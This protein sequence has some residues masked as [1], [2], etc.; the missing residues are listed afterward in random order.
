MNLLDFQDKNSWTK[1]IYI[2][3]DSIEGSG[4]RGEVTS[5]LESSGSGWG[6]DDEDSARSPS[7]SG[8]GPIIADPDP[9]SAPDTGKPTDAS[10]ERGAHPAPTE[11]PPKTIDEDDDDDDF[12]IVDDVKP[13]PHHPDVDID[14]INPIDS[15]VDS[16]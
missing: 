11:H 13:D 7:G 14:Q 4:A 9:D 5:D 16:E 15:G 2:D 10:A 3:D 6:P 8:A 1:D 12:K